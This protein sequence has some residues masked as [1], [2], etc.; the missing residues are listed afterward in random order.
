MNVK[1]MTMDG[2]NWIFLLSHLK[3]TGNQA[4]GK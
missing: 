2:K 4:A 3:R 1:I